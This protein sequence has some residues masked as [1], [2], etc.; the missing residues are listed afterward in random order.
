MDGFILWFWMFEDSLKLSAGNLPRKENI[1][2][3]SLARL[4]LS[5]VQGVRI[6]QQATGTALAVAVQ[7]VKGE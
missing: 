5:G 6:P 3:N 7:S 2:F 1:I 4:H